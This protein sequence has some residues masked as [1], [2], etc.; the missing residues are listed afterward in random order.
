VKKQLTWF[1]RDIHS[2]VRLFHWVDASQPLEHIVSA[3]KKEYWRHPDFPTELEGSELR[4]NA[5]YKERKVLKYYEVT[6]RFSI[7]T[8]YSVFCEVEF[9]VCM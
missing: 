6:N 1:R 4:K 7:L 2:E 8:F 3:L 5:S 9:Y